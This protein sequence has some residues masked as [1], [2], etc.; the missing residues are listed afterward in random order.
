MSKGKKDKNRVFVVNL[1]H[2][3]IFSPY[4]FSYIYGD[5]KQLNGFDFEG[6]SYDNLRELVRK[7]VHAPVNSLYYCKVGKTLKQGLRP[8]E[9]G[10]D[11]QEFLK[12]EY[13]SK[14]VVDLYVEHHG[15]DPMDYKNSNARDYESF[16]SSDAYCSR[17]DEQV[18]RDYA[19]LGMRYDHPKQLKLALANYGV[20]GGSRK[21]GEGTSKDGEESSR[22]YDVS[23]KWTKSKIASSRKNGQPQCGFREL[24]KLE[25]DRAAAGMDNQFSIVQVNYRKLNLLELCALH[26]DSSDMKLLEFLLV[27]DSKNHVE[28]NVAMDLSSQF[29]SS[30]WANEELISSRLKDTLL[31]DK[32]RPY[33]VVHCNKAVIQGNEASVADESLT[34]IIFETLLPCVRVPLIHFA[35]GIVYYITRWKYIM[36]KEVKRESKVVRWLVKWK[37]KWKKLYGRTMSLWKKDTGSLDPWGQGSFEEKGIVMRLTQ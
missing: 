7:L 28:P 22:N 19:I 1:K 18:M 14:W 13:E 25:K 33:L 4:L 8:L 36:P 27:S 29:S 26:I 17:D 24:S 32:R 2:D 10:A 5:E 23:P 11:V 6:M 3:V 30:K 37:W 20:A 12:V 21:V 9:N 31:T 35:A 16:D 34:F 15:Y